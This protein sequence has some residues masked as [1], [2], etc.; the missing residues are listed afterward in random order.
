MNNTQ[1]QEYSSIDTLAIL[2]AHQE[3]ILK[4]IDDPMLASRLIS[5]GILPG[6]LLKL[7][8]STLRGHTCII[9]AGKHYFAMRKNEVNALRVQPQAKA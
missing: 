3:V 4:D 1:T 6:M 2:Q 5:M 7:V 9:L 8:R